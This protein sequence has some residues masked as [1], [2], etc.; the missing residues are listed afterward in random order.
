M[1]IIAFFAGLFGHKKKDPAPMTEPTTVTQPAEPTEPSS[2]PT[3]PSSQPTESSSEPTEPSSEPTEPT[4]REYTVTFKGA[5]GET[6]L[7]LVLP[8]GETPVYTGATPEK[9]PTAQYT[10]AF[11]GW[12]PAPAPVTGEATYTAT[13]TATVNSYPVTFKNADGSVRRILKSVL[14]TLLE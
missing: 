6:L 4:V 10:Y 13:F 1:A 9:A 7:S 14:N 12:D 11:A 5:N 8:E 2:E 3:E